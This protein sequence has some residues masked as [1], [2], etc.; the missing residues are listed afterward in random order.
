MCEDEPIYI[1]T[2]LMPGG[3]LLSLLRTMHKNK[4][5][6]SMDVLI[7]MAAQ[8]CNARHTT[9]MVIAVASSEYTNDFI[10][11][12]ALWFLLSIYLSFFFF[13]S[14]PNLSGRRLDVYRTTTHG[15]AVA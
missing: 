9:V 6:L 11:M 15:V 4:Q 13:F 7:D 12:V 10:L 3:S 8:V 14:S 2:E 5:D 1:V